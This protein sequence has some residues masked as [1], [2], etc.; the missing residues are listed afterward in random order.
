[1]AQRHRIGQWGERLAAHFAE[2]Q[3]WAILASNYRA[4]PTELDLVC[5]TAKELIILEVKV[6][7]ERAW[8]RAA[9]SITPAQQKH[10]ARAAWRFMHEQGYTD[11]PLRFDII[12]I[13]LEAEQGHQLQHYPDAFRL[14]EGFDPSAA[15]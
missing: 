7:S 2:R 12:A 5:A 6:R 14:P 9:E 4:G 15:L 11:W 13:Q 3:Q 1:V 10:L 8:A